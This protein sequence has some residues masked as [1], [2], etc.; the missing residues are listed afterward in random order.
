MIIELEIAGVPMNFLVDTGVNYTL[1]FDNN[2]ARALDIKKGAPFYL[3]GLGNQTPME[4]HKIAIPSINFKSFSL[5]N[6]EILILPES[7][8]LLSKRAGTQIDGIIGS[9]LFREFPITINYQKQ[10]L[11]L[12]PPNIQRKRRH[13]K[14]ISKPL[15]FYKRKPYVHFK[16]HQ[17]ESKSIEGKGLIDTGLSDALWLFSS[18]EEILAAPPLISVFL[19]TG[20]NGD[21]FGQRG[22]VKQISFGEYSLSEVKVAYPDTESISQVELAENRI[23]S[24]GAEILSR[25]EVLLDYPNSEL[26]L[27]PHSNTKQPFY[28]NLSGVELAYQ[29]VEVVKERL[30]N[31]VRYQTENA[32]TSAE[33]FLASRFQ[34]IFY[35]TIVV[36]YVRP[37]SAAAKAGV[38]VGDI[39]HRVD[40]K[41]TR[42]MRLENVIE[43]LK[44]N[45]QTS[46]TK[47]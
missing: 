4:A 28:Y 26:K 14:V 31:V 33:I 2:K 8:F 44:K 5:I 23:G 27:K 15:F 30:P 37:G 43:A 11:H 22:K 38:K 36:N 21:V 42:Y 35:P 1:L 3:R 17:N 45:R 46:Q 47:P 29:G 32:H 9:A 10:F 39:I 24:I 41:R 19:G 40:G 6:Q 34:L 20:I 16:V 18:D 7:E 13:S 12:N 25:F